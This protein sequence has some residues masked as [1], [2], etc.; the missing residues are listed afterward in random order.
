MI[1]ELLRLNIDVP[2]EEFDL[3][4]SERIRKLSRR[5]WTSV[6]TAKLVS[7]FLAEKSGTRVLDIGS[8]VGKFCMVGASHTRGYFVGV[9]RRGDLFEI[10]NT[11]TASYDIKNVKFIH[12][13][14]TSIQFRNYDAFYFYNSFHEN[15]AA[16]GQIDNK[17]KEDLCLYDLYTLFTYEQFS[18]LPAGT[19]IVTY[20]SPPEIIPATF[21][22]IYSLKDDLLNFWEKI[23]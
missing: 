14:I 19:R 12:S 8:G 16:Y 1:F 6:S 22:L 18:S 2:D 10:A 5:H 3:I 9:E 11:L 13:N 7:E 15:I 21:R 20:H 23:A 17:V 4:Y